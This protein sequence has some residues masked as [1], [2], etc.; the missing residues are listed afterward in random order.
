MS[1]RD[2]ERAYDEHIEELEAENEELAIALLLRERAGE[3]TAEGAPLD[4]VIRELG[5]TRDELHERR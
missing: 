3:S 2:C 1:D 5:F 4:V